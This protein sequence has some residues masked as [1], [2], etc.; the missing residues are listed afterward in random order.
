MAYP[1]PTVEELAAFSGRPVASYTDF[2]AEALA[3]ATLLFVLVTEVTE[4]PTD[5]ELRKL[6]TNA[7]LQMADDIYLKQPFVA[8]QAKPFSSE[9]IGSYSYSL[10]Q[11]AVAFQPDR[12]TGLFWWDLALAKFIRTDTGMASGSIQ[13][14]EST[15]E[16]RRTESGALELLGPRDIEPFPS[17]FPFD[18]NIP[19]THDPA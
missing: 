14:F 13:V 11:G 7:I 8:V 5:P 6:V 15:V 10:R 1:V 16:F 3:Q 12:R 9:T 19:T 4:P 2:A 17:G 18:Y